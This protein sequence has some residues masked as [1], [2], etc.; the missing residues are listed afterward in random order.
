[1]YQVLCDGYPLLDYR[2]NDLILV[3]PKVK[4][5]A[6]KVGE[7]SFT[8]YKNHP[9]YGNLK[10]ARSV[11][12]ISDEIGVIFRGRI[13]GDTVDFDNGKAVDLEGAL[14]YF[15]DSVVRPF[16]FPKDVERNT[17][18][19]AASKS[20]NVIQFFLKWLIDRHNEQV[21]DFQEF[22][23]GRVTVT[24]PNNYLYRSSTDYTNTWE[25]L[26]SKL[27]DSALGGYLCIR[28]EADGN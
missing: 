7:A 2:D 22:K 14:A 16:E 4:L 12:E 21:Q 28:Y 8:I 18:Y 5:A 9:Y 27:F 19:I 24:D 15:N 11:V 20:G 17:E 10:H 6:N 25:T 3:A 23:L 1:M 26:K 13:T